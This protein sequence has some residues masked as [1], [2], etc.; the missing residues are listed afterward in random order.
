MLSLFLFD[1]DDA[2]ACA[3]VSCGLCECLLCELLA[4]VARHDEACSVIVVRDDVCGLAVPLACECEG[5]Y[6]VKVDESLFGLRGRFGV[7]VCFHTSIIVRSRRYL[8]GFGEFLQILS[9]LEFRCA[10]RTH[11][12][13]DR[14]L[15]LQATTAGA[16]D[17][18]Q[19]AVRLHSLKGSG[20][21]GP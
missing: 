16:A 14:G 21:D 5:L 8:S 1:G 6:S 20:E 3:S 12:Q 2:E 10:D 17:S 18:V 7:C 15:V 4:S 19:L 13:V 9:A 11:S